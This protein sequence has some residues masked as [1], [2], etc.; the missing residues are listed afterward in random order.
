MSI[1]K[2]EILDSVTT[3]IVIDIMRE[4]GSK[5]YNK[6]IDRKTGQTCLWFKTICHCGDSHKLC[7]FTKSKDFFCYTSCG[8][9]DFFNFIK[10]IKNI[11]DEDFYKVIAYIGEKTGKTNLYYRNKKGFEENNLEIRKAIN[12]IDDLLEK[13]NK[14]EVEINK[15]Y[16]ENILNYFD[17]YTF[18]E[19]WIKD[20]IS[21][22]SMYK[23]NIRW[24]ELEKHI[25]IPHYNINDQLVGIRRRSL[26][27]EDIKNKYMP[28]YIEGILYEHPLG[29]NLYGLNNNKDRIKK[30]KKAIIVEGE[31]SVLLSDTFFGRNSITIA[32]CGFNI[33]DWQLNTL[34]KL[35]VE[36][37][38]IAFD[39]DFEFFNKEKYQKDEKTKKD[40]NNYKLR[41]KTICERI[42][43]YCRVSIIL[44]KENKL[45][46]KDS[47]FDKGKTI[48][49]YLYKNRKEII[50]GSK[51]WEQ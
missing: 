20:G 15:F 46:I 26:K 18:Y 49:E 12:K 50:N 28:E 4:N 5:V 3:D 1:D 38:T 51:I 34:L 36:E 14:K 40:Y 16:D 8:R 11:K 7:F 6:T 32:T 44:D 24:Y 37:I 39:K 25:I 33:S 21:I 47:P 48:F 19:G 17:P 41:L 31:K 43:P 27:A 22:K 42:V 13:K 23:F 45:N 9:M 10:K 29:L 2:K 30:S 35:G